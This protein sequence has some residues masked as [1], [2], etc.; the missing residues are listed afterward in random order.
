MKTLVLNGPNLNR[1]GKREPAVYGSQTLADL[2]ALCVTTGKEL[3]LEVDFRQTNHEGELLEWLHEAADNEYPVVLNAAAW[4]HTSVAVGDACAQLTA[5]LVE[6][7]LSNVHKR[8]PFR[9]HSYV[10]AHAAGVI[11]GLGPSGYTAALRFIAA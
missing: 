4:T 6:V 3:G 5:P 11:A 7:H 8:E 9:H 1:L 2:E 10:S